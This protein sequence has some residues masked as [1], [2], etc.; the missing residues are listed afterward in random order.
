MSDVALTKF[1]FTFQDFII[2]T[3][4]T[5]LSWL[6]IIC[7]LWTIQQQKKM[8]MSENCPSKVA[9]RNSKSHK[10]LSLVSLRPYLSTNIMYHNSQDVIPL[11]VVSGQVLDSQVQGLTQLFPENKNVENLLAWCILAHLSCESSSNSLYASCSL[12]YL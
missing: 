1:L 3:M 11:S 5:I 7:L 10:F 9:I 8:E 2:T 4:H 6:N 12:V